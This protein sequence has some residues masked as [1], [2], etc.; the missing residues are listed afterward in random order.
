MVSRAQGWGL[1]AIAV[2]I[3]VGIAGYSSTPRFWGL[4]AASPSDGFIIVNSP[5]IYTR[6]RL[7]N[8][9]LTQTA[10]LKEQL[11]V[12]EKAL[13][14]FNSIGQILSSDTENKLA[15]K[16]GLAG[17]PPLSAAGVPTPEKDATAGDAS[18]KKEAAAPQDQ[19]SGSGPAAVSDGAPFR[20]GQT[21]TDLFHALNNYREEIRAEM[22][23][24]LLDDRHD[25][26]GNTIYRL[27]FDATVLAGRGANDLALVSV[28]LEHNPT[29]FKAEYDGVYNEWATLMLRTVNESLDGIAKQLF[30]RGP[31]TRVRVMMSQFLVQHLCR[32]AIEASK[33]TTPSKKDDLKKEENSEDYPEECN[34]WA[35]KP[36]RIVRRVTDLLDQ[37]VDQYLWKR[38][39]TAKRRFYQNLQAANYPFTAND[40]P[41]IYENA[42]RGCTRNLEGKRPEK[43]E[44][45]DKTEK[46]ELLLAD[47]NTIQVDCPPIVPFEGLLGG[48]RLYEALIQDQDRSLHSEL[49]RVWRVYSDDVAT[50]EIKAAAVKELLAKTV[51]PLCAAEADGV[52][53]SLESPRLAD[54]RCIAADYIRWLLNGSGKL[55]SGDK[56]RID[57]Y[58]D[59]NTVG[60]H[61]EDCN[62]AVT[63]KPT[64]ETQPGSSPAATL[65]RENLNNSAE[66]YAY[67]VSPRNPSRRIANS[68]GVQRTLERILDVRGSTGLAEAGATVDDSRRRAERR[69]EIESRPFIIPFGRS[70]NLPM[71]AG[72]APIKTVYKTDFGWA[73]AP[74]RRDDELEYED[75]QHPLAAV[76]SLPG[77]WRSVDLKV[78]TCWI[79]RTAL[80]QL[81]AIQAPPSPSAA[82]SAPA[83]GN[84]APSKAALTASPT[85]AAAPTNIPG[86]PASAGLQAADLCSVG[87]SKQPPQTE[88]VRLPGTIQEVSRKLGFEVIDEP[89][90][91][92]DQEPQVLQAGYAGEILLTGGRLWR[93]TEVTLGSQAAE[94]ITVLPNM[95]GI[96]ARFEC[97]RP[98]FRADGVKVEGHRELVAVKV[99]TSEGVAHNPT[100][101]RLEN[102]GSKPVHG[103]ESCDDSAGRRPKNPVP[104]EVSNSPPRG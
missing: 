30:N 56:K 98:Q 42:V 70:R 52:C 54:L 61:L 57:T 99:W 1:A 60:R 37:Y 45:T 78:T 2:A 69:L 86:Q 97:V 34:V 64:V 96:I 26:Q 67:N 84:I 104:Q 18:P 39:E 68:V 9:R 29:R 6:Q 72:A 23:H 33:A 20:I 17:R 38:E 7:V 92:A 80:K 53:F 32:F 83:P 10:W 79:P 50:T 47:K 102:Q 73:I 46:M 22:M 11:D 27:A 90:L 58:L 51:P 13:G 35:A 63:T 62:V 59:M 82:V 8:D 21:T 28:T 93:S 43:T 49:D 101:V 55:P 77:W 31:E 65:L 88:V 44:K 103:A 24:T 94:R 40:F 36:S 66:V 76:V 41:F 4:F 48:L 95:K 100:M 85:P 81:T 71:D 91:D 16:L 25:I 87:Q 14:T 12:T 15:A 19:K 75:R 3:V 5:S 74:H 89:S